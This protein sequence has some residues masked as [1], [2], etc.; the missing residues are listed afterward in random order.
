MT[1]TPPSSQA[2]LD[3]ARAALHVAERA[4]MQAN[5]DAISD[6]AILAAT[7]R[8]R[9]SLRAALVSMHSE[10]GWYHYTGCPGDTGGKCDCAAGAIV[11]Q[12]ARVLGV[13][14]SE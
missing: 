3:R 11:R 2:E 7:L 1:E 8:E 12:A 5:A 9:D 4:R 14:K 10:F 13:D 6:R